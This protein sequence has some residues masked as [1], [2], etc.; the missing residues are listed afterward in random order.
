MKIVATGLLA[1]FSMLFTFLIFEVGMQILLE[2]S[3]LLWSETTPDPVLRFR[4]VPGSGG[5]DDWGF[6][7]KRIPDSVDIITLGDSMTWGGAGVAVP[8][9]ENWPSQ[10]GRIKGRSVY[11]FGVWAYGPAHYL[12]LLE[13]RGLSLKPQTVIVGLYLGNDFH[14]AYTTVR[15][16][17]EWEALRTASMGPFDPAAN[18]WSAIS[19][20]RHPLVVVRDF[21]RQRSMIW[22]SLE[23][24]VIGQMINALGDQRDEFSGHGCTVRTD[25]PFPSLIQAEAR[26]HALNPDSVVV[27]EGIGLAE[28]FIRRIAEVTRKQGIELVIVLIPTKESVLVGYRKTV[29]TEC[30]RVLQRLIAAEATY[31]EKMIDYL[32]NQGI[33]FVDPLEDMRDEAKRVRLY[34]R[35][36]DS[37]PVARG[38]ALI[39]ESIAKAELLP[40][41]LEAQDGRHRKNLDT[42]SP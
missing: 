13:T 30:E 20:P 39:A 32:G 38:Y 16:S 2:P 40:T 28:F 21:M 8:V 36:A 22:T 34:M 12:Y 4:V 33:P 42:T 6:R 10:Y 9:Q 26:F 3:D 18:P 23:A 37:H 31:R 25:E 1:V 24:G 19:S 11:N 14:D 35:S 15:D 17:S 7:N 41:S 27:R 29:S 5:H